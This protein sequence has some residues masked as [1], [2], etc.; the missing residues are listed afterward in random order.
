MA[1]NIGAVKPGS[2]ADVLLDEPV[3][4]LQDATPQSSIFA[5]LAQEG[6]SPEDV[7]MGEAQASP[8]PAMGM[9]SEGEFDQI[10]QQ[11][12]DPMVAAM[13]M[14]PEEEAYQLALQQ[15]TEESQQILPITERRQDE[16]VTSWDISDQEADGGMT[17]RA[18]KL[19][20]AMIR[21]SRQVR[22]TTTAVAPA[23]D[24]SAGTTMGKIATNLGAANADLMTGEFNIDPLFSNIMSVYAEDYFASKTVGVKLDEEAQTDEQMFGEGVLPE[25]AQTAVQNVEVKKADDPRRLGQDIAREWSRTQGV[26]EE[27][28]QPVDDK[29]A[30]FLGDYAKEIYAHAMGEENVQRVTTKEGNKSTTTFILSGTMIKKLQSSQAYRDQIMPKKFVRPSKVPTQG[31]KVKGP[32]KSLTK[33]V[34]G[35]IAKGRIS[36]RE[37]D[38]AIHNSGTIPNVVRP[39]RLRILFSTILPALMTDHRQYGTNELLDIF[40][41]I[42]NFGPDKVSKYSAIQ[43]QKNKNG[44]QYDVDAEM[45]KLK[46][47]IAQ[48]VLGISMERNGANYFQ[49]FMQAYNGRL[50]PQASLFNPT[51]SKAVRFVTSNA[52]PT[53][54]KPASKMV[55][56]AFQAYALVIGLNNVDGL[57]PSER[58]AAML[59]QAPQLERWGNILKEVM[60]NS[61]SAKDADA[62]AEAIAN[63]I[64]MNDPRFPQVKPLA[65]DPNNSE[66]AALLQ[67]IK[68][69]GEDGPA[70]IDGLIDFANFRQNMRQ[71]KTHYSYLNPTI[72][73]KTNGPASNGMQMGDEKIAFR[74][75]VLRTPN[76]KYAVDGDKDIRDELNSIMLTSLDEGFEGHFQNEADETLLVNLGKAVVNYRNLNK[77]ITMTFGYGKDFP[78]FQKDIKDT[79]FLLAESDPAVKNALDVLESNKGGKGLT[80]DDAASMILSKYIPAVAQVMSEDG[81]LARHLLWGTA[82]VSSLADIPVEMRGPTGLLMSFG[83]MAPESSESQGTY[84]IDGRQVRVNTYEGKP[85]AGAIK[86]RVNAKGETV[87]DVGGKAWGGIIPGPVQA[88]DAATVIK[89]FSGKSWNKIRKATGNKPYIHQIYDAFKFD[90]ATYAVAAEEVNNNWVNA[91]LDWSYLHEAQGAVEKAIIAIR[92]QLDEL[93][94][95]N[96][97][98]AT[99]PMLGSLLGTVR[100]T[101]DGS[102]IFVG[103]LSK[104]KKLS[105]YIKPA[106]QEAWAME[107]HNKI[108]RDT[109]LKYF[110]G[111]GVQSLTK[112][113][114]KKFYNALFSHTNIRTRIKSL[115]EKTDKKKQQLKAKILASKNPVYQYYAH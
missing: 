4:K 1:I 13:G 101:P 41:T 62:I 75:G 19:R 103:L 38:E 48:Q 23:L 18:A 110:K 10:S 16:R 66:H 98:V 109:G 89:T 27:Q 59:K 9:F 50:T 111:D 76:S 37:I 28:I 46:N 107:V 24:F 31:G 25:A 85:T 32:Q 84:K 96:V 39:E 115:A 58:K 36:S 64:P 21:G 99:M 73:G 14:S 79:I 42:N 112:D 83:G 22:D 55:D 45:A 77:A 108:I 95:G 34:S 6:M 71:G 74:T 93:P 5:N 61:M 105:P 54:I 81:I 20:Q 63:G 3:Q 40:A 113:Q 72:D 49:Y 57:I 33:D 44:Q 114:L 29:T 68:E 91:S 78:S 65:L 8:S 67:K 88:I 17:E 106:E 92:K 56:A 43:N 104:L 2:R 51:T 82:L 80:I 87:E 100:T 70:F 97:D 90:I 86:N 94:D 12:Q 7:A 26:P 102:K 52:T 30:A 11:Q 69:K 47:V 60:D 53:A 35:K 15:Q